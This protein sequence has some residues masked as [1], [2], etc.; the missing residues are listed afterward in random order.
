MKGYCYYNNNTHEYG[1]CAI[2]SEANGLYEVVDLHTGEV[3]TLT[4]ECFR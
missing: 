3:F 1:L 4:L 2:L